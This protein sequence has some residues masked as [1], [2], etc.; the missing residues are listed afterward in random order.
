MKNVLII[1]ADGFEDSEALTTR[2]ILIRSGL[3][4]TTSTIRDNTLNVQSS[5]GL[6]LVADTT[7]YDIVNILDYDAIILPGGKRGVDNLNKSPLL[8]KYLQELYDNH[9]LLCAI[10]AAPAII[11]RMSLLRG[12]NFTCYSGFELGYKGNYTGSTLE[13]S[14]NII[15]AR[16]MLYSPDFALAIIEYLLGKEVREQVWQGIS[17]TK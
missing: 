14:D 11:G 5:F 4:V 12:K 16:S 13:I 3:H 6:T 9:H 17:S 15:T 7:I 1:L 2:D 8:I 10:C